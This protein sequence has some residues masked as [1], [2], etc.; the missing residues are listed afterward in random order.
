MGTGHNNPSPRELP[1]SNQTR[2]RY[3]TPSKLENSLVVIPDNSDRRAEGMELTDEPLLDWVDVLILIDDHYTEALSKPLA[4]ANDRAQRTHGLLE[5]RRIVK[6][7][8]FTQECPVLVKPFMDA[9]TGKAP[10]DY[11][12][13]CN[14]FKQS[15]F[16]RLFQ[17][18]C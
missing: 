18:L 8:F 10:V 5:Y 13:K 9:R 12:A 3:V 6:I 11:D 14:G 2:F 1:L 7:A 17:A 4:H 16:A 15:G